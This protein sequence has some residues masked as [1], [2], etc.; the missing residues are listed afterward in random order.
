M[1][2][3]NLD[4]GVSST[5]F[6]NN[7]SDNLGHDES[8]S[9]FE[10]DESREHKREVIIK[11]T[12]RLGVNFDSLSLRNEAASV[13]RETVSAHVE[14]SLMDENKK[15]T[16]LLKIEVFYLSNR[17]RLVYRGNYRISEARYR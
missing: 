11:D 2:K 16:L 9:S 14:K 17:I 13:R 1:N 5:K 4:S 6:E 15:K 7:S 3:E 10:M 12:G 8:G